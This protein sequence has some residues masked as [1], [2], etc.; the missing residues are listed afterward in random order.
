MRDASVLP[1]PLLVYSIVCRS[2]P[3][4]AAMM[5]AN[6]GVEKTVHLDRR[7]VLISA[8]CLHLPLY[9]VDG[10]CAASKGAVSPRPRVAAPKY[11]ARSGRQY[12][13]AGVSG[14]AGAVFAGQM[15]F[16]AE[17]VGS[18]WLRLGD[19]DC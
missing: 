15:P 8:C 1:F 3:P 16:S 7:W 17:L 10:S 4:F 5:P 14:G 19:R 11:R 6:R 13:A 9:R 18:R 2:G 12:A